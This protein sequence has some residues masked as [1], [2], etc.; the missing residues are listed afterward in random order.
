MKDEKSENESETDEQMIAR[1]TRSIT[2]AKQM[3]LRSRDIALTAEWNF[4]NATRIASK[5]DRSLLS[6]I[7]RSFSFVFLRKIARNA[8]KFLTIAYRATRNLFLPAARYD[9]LHTFVSQR[10]RLLRKS[11]VLI[12]TPAFTGVFIGSVCV[13]V[14]FVWKSLGC[15]CFPACFYSYL[16][17]R[18]ISDS[19][20]CYYF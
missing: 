7:A 20:R 2:V 10:P 13:C 4:Q 16:V 9:S 17:A 19:A 8:E 15:V 1:V 18:Q 14:Y 5:A 11:L 12:K 6:G 3:H